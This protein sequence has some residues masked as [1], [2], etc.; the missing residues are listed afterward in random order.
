MPGVSVATSNDVDDAPFKYTCLFRTTL[1][2][3][4]ATITFIVSAPA[5]NCRL[6]VL[7][8]GL[9]YKLALNTLL[10]PVFIAAPLEIIVVVVRP[11]TDAFTLIVKACWSFI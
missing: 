1:P 7:R 2:L 9:G 6:Q 4:S 5:V 10:S 11:V 8:T 3:A